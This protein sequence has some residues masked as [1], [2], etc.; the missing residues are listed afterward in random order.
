MPE[1]A[2][3][4]DIKG[5]CNWD[6]TLLMSSTPRKIARTNTKIKSPIDMWGSPFFEMPKM[7]LGIY[8]PAHHLSA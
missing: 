4:P 2:L 1:I 6:G 3:V 8:T 5:V 7:I